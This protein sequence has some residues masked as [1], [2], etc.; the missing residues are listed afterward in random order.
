MEIDPPDT[1]YCVV[2]PNC[3]IH[4]DGDPIKREDEEK[5]NEGE[6]VCVQCGVVCVRSVV[7]CVQ[8]SMV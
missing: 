5:L 6:C 2:E 7:S 3:V 8:C 1:E 4:C